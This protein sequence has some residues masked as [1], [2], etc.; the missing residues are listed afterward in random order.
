MV[1]GAEAFTFACTFC[2]LPDITSGRTFFRDD[3]LDFNVGE[4][5]NL[6][7]LSFQGV[8]EFLFLASHQVVFAPAEGCIE[9]A[10]GHVCPPDAHIGSDGITFAFEKAGFLTF[11]DGRNPDVSPFPKPGRSMPAFK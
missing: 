6:L 1:Q 4:I 9:P 11:V 8:E 5:V 7:A 2:Q 10:F 3:V